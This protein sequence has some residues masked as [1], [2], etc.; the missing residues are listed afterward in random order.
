[1]E[2]QKLKDILKDKVKVAYIASFTALGIFACLLLIRID[3]GNHN[4]LRRSLQETNENLDIVKT[5]AE[6]RI[7]INEFNSLFAVVEKDAN[8]LIGI[9]TDV[10]KEKSVP[11][12]LVKPL[13]G[14]VSSGYKKISVLVEGRAPY[15][16][17]ANFISG[18]ENNEKYLIIEE[19]E[20]KTKDAGP[21]RE[22]RDFGSG[23][24][25]PV[26]ETEDMGIS[27]GSFSPIAPEEI[28]AED[29]AF[30]TEREAVFKLILTCF[31][32]QG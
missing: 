29:T 11:L 23:S 6:Y 17:M 5:V 21:S 24:P 26:G 16:D 28:Q 31:R 25:F 7:H 9:I 1:M 8:W 27:S 18:L 14:V 4:R 2:L 13:E 32:V 22:R 19:F 30:R 15:H 12:N 3:L 20:F 10:A